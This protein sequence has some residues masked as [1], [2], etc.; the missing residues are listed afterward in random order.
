MHDVFIV[1]VYILR[2]FFVLYGNT[3]SHLE[4]DD[5]PFICSCLEQYILEICT[6]FL[7]IP[8]HNDDA[9]LLNLP[10]VASEN[11]ISK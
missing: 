3:A 2:L 6:D 4:T 11:T 7:G 1:I 8:I 10:G 5:F 9:L